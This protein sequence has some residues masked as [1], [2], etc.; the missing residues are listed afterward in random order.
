MV[1]T[2][3]V[4]VKSL[5]LSPI[6]MITVERIVIIFNLQLLIVFILSTYLKISLSPFIPWLKVLKNFKPSFYQKNKMNT[7]FMWSEVYNFSFLF[8]GFQE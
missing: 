3:L 6:R 8:L 2:I 4:K 1:V 7:D 5:P